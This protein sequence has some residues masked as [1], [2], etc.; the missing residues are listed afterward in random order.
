MSVTLLHRTRHESVPTR[1]AV[2]WIV[3]TVRTPATSKTSFRSAAV[4]AAVRARHLPC[5]ACGTE[6]G[7]SNAAGV[8]ISR[9][10][11]GYGFDPSWSDERRR[12]ALIERCYGP[13][14]TSRLTQLGVAAGWRCLDV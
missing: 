7:R 8:G 13:I 1:K 3:G 9:P 10:V 2:F 6:V 14:T 5:A 11:E 12:L 4:L